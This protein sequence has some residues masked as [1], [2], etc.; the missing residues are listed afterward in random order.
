M[1]PGQEGH[2]KGRAA[3][4]AGLPAAAN[5]YDAAAYPYT[6]EGLRRQGWMNGY[7]FEWFKAGCPK[8]SWPSADN[9]YEAHEARG[10]V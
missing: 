7:R 6:D 8:G 4:L 5:P 3:Y 2:D 1:K 9:T 10:E